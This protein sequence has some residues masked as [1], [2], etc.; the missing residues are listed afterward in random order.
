MLRHNSVLPRW[1]ATISYLSVAIDCF[2]KANSGSLCRILVE[3]QMLVT[4]RQTYRRI[5]PSL[6]VPF[7]LCGVDNRKTAMVAGNQPW[8]H[9]QWE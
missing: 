6:K 3:H 2:I 5:A 1:V 4:D 9:S 8:T 7:P